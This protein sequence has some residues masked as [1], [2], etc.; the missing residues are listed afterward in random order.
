MAT[1]TFDQFS[2]TAS[3]NGLTSVATQRTS[4]NSL[5]NP[6]P[7]EQQK[8]FN[9]T[10]TSYSTQSNDD[11]YDHQSLE[12]QQGQNWRR[13]SSPNL[14]PESSSTSNSNNNKNGL[15][16]NYCD[17]TSSSQQSSQMDSSVSQSMPTTPV[18]KHS[19]PM[20]D[21][22]GT[23]NIDDK[24]SSSSAPSSRRSSMNRSSGSGQAINSSSNGNSNMITPPQTPGIKSPTKANFSFPPSVTSC[25]QIMPQKV[26]RKRITQEQL[27]DLVAMF[28]QTDTPSYDVREKLAKKLNMTNREVQV[29]FQN[30]RAKANRAKAN[31]HSASHQHHRFLHHHSVST[32]QAASGHASSINMLPHGNFTFVPMFANGGP[33]TGGPVRG[34][35]NRRHSYVSPPTNNNQ[36][37]VSQEAPL[38]RPRASTV[39][40]APMTSMSSHM[41]H[42]GSH[43]IHSAPQQHQQSSQK[44]MGIPPPIKIMSYPHEH[45]FGH[46]HH[47]PGYA[48]SVPPSPISPIMPITPISPTTPTLPP[49][50]YMLSNI[51]NLTLPPPVPPIKDLLSS[52]YQ[53]SAYQQQSHN[54][55]QQQQILLPAPQSR[56]SDVTMTKATEVNS[57]SEPSLD[58]L[59]TAAELVQSEEKE[60]ERLKALTIKIEPQE[61][62]ENDKKSWRPWLI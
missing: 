41:S 10:S 50:N 25:E 13:Y 3:N 27:Q 40:G 38:T 23:N 54:S 8:S 7:D 15:T 34:R 12:N 47:H 49:I 17:D 42:I 35:S 18:L 30:R 19:S 59:A 39:T 24:A 61:E 28:E 14:S 36:K 52:E 44:L 6:E 51:N 4:I 16:I 48:Y 60:K 46:S 58:L 56:Y 43:S 20:S 1:N 22:N 9:T 29:W 31:E 45:H 62:I 21:Y 32:T 55:H 5:L 37:K 33:S 2:K 53:Q 57:S 11:W 26:K